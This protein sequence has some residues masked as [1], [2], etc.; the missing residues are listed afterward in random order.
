MFSTPEQIQKAE[1]QLSLFSKP[2]C[3]GCS[4][5]VSM[6]HTTPC[7]GTVEDIE[8]IMDA[9]YSKNLM[10]DWWL[11]R[12]EGMPSYLGHDNPF[13]EDIPYLV[14]ALK[15][16]E[17]SRAPFVRKGT[18]NLLVDDKC[19]IHHIKPVQGRLSCCKIERVYEEDGEQ[20]DLDERLLILHT[21]NSQRGRDLIERW[22]TEVG[23]TESD[24]FEQP[25]SLQ[26]FDMML[27]LVIKDEHEISEEE[28]KKIK[29]E[30]TILVYEKPF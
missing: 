16:H 21:W 18:C 13:T 22:K 10:L 20:K 7:I 12:P 8:R 30:R 5:G 25:D 29:A 4:R 17:G 23:F 19:S 3:D 24:E 26:V 14:P 6:C 2:S 15:G 27:G 28:W 1:K 9:G 11:G